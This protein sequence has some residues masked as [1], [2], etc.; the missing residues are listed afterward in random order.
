[1]GLFDK[2]TAFEP[3]EYPQAVQY[4]E[5]I[6]HSY[7]LASEFS[8]TADVQDFSVVLD[9]QA[10]G[11]IKRTLLAISQ[12]E[13]AVKRF[14]ADLGRR[15]PKPE[16]DQVGC[17]FAESEVRH[18]DAYSH[19]LRVLGLR[20]DFEAALED[21][22]LS[23]RTSSLT[24]HLRSGSS[25]KDFAFSL[26]LFTVFIENVSL[27]S[28]FAIIQSFWKH[29]RVLKD[30][31]NVVQATRKEESVH[32]RFGAWLVGRIKEERPEWFGPGF[33]DR[34]TDSC[35]SAFH[36]ESA[37]LDWIFC[38]GVPEFLDRQVLGDYVR[39]RMNR[40]LESVGGVA[41]FR[42]GAAEVASLAWFDEEELATCNADFFHKRPV[43]YSKK[44]QAVKAEELF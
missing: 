26:A 31:D 25:D 38:D 22:A 3:F 24:A 28:Q 14:W 17:V 1:M 37:I 29:A 44:Q 13:V 6:Q 35:L 18:A 23:S 39:S 20:S 40:G 2:R 11:V 12:V 9:H 16:I 19:L 33:Y 43:T 7:W 42:V 36:A 27:F 41:P 5:A 10:R 34:L 4:K 32:A 30:V 15:I 8:F 21:P